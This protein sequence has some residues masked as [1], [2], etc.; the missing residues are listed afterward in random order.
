MH[1]NNKQQFTPHVQHCTSCTNLQ[2]VLR[3]CLH[4]LGL[5]QFG[6]QGTQCEEVG[7]GVTNR[8]ERSYTT[9][10]QRKE[11]HAKREQIFTHFFELLLFLLLQS[12]LLAA[13]L[14]H[15]AYVLLTT[16][17]KSERGGGLQGRETPLTNTHWESMVLHCALHHC[18]HLSMSYELAKPVKVEQSSH[19]LER[20]D[21]RNM[22]VRK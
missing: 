19:S 20:E 18:T 2:L 14:L 6:L 1:N 13:L 9:C 4:Q 22:A 7:K 10:R 12:L 16:L 15:W 17:I 3:H 5:L 21:E 8:Q 11:E